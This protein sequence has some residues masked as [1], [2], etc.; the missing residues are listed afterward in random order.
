[1]AGYASLIAQR[2]LDDLEASKEY[3]DLDPASQR[4]ARAIALQ[5]AYRADPQYASVREWGVVFLLGL[6]RAPFV[7]GKRFEP[8]AYAGSKMHPSLLADTDALEYA[9][10]QQADDDQNDDDCF[11]FLYEMKIIFHF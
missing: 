3:Q 9:A 6:A 8:K 1:M 7:D 4:E 2:L 10:E 11:L 5:D